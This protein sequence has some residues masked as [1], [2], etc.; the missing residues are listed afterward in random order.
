MAVIQAG[1][2]YEEA[3]Q[4]SKEHLPSNSPLRLEVPA[5]TFQSVGSWF[6]SCSLLVM[7][8][9]VFGIVCLQVALSYSAYLIDVLGD[10]DRACQLAKE[11]FDGT[12]FSLC[13]GH[14]AY[15]GVSKYFIHVN[16]I[17]MQ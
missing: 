13:P 1:N 6:P 8:M 14:L 10:S 11:A 12:F 17:Q 2:S 7:R 3:W 4:L 9:S 5:P 16:F 15:E